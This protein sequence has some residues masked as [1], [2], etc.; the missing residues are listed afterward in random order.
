MIAETITI[1]VNYA[2]HDVTTSD[3]VG[4]C[5]YV[6][7]GF[8]VTIISFFMTRELYGIV[9]PVTEDNNKAMQYILGNLLMICCVSIGL[10]GLFL[11][12]MSFEIIQCV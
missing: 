3:W 9:F 11:I 8:V 5:I 12:V 4:F 7:L 1:Y 2:K 10:L 6:F